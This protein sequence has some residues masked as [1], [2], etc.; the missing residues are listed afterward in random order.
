MEDLITDLSA[1]TKGKLQAQSNE[2][3][4]AVNA[5]KNNADW[6]KQVERNIVNP[7]SLVH[8]VNKA[9][10]GIN[11]NL[12]HGNGGGDIKVDIYYAKY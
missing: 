10:D 11:R 7:N 6:S 9:K 2:L 5:L 12:I 8:A 3:T 1:A 4:R